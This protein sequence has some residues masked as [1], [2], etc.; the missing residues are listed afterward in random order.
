MPGLHVPNKQ[1]RGF[2]NVI[3]YVIWHEDIGWVFPAPVILWAHLAAD[4]TFLCS[5]SFIFFAPCL[6]V[7]RAYT[8][9]LG[10]TWNLL[11]V[12]IIFL[13]IGLRGSCISCICAWREHRGNNDNNSSI[14]AVLGCW[15]SVSY[16]Q[17]LYLTS[18]KMTIT[19]INTLVFTMFVET[20]WFGQIGSG[21]ILC[22]FH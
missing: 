15:L 10:T 14:T 16:L 13:G 6:Y 19:F 1:V 7:E 18:C 5:Y 17:L 21:S 20:N 8:Q 22:R 12:W 9:V 3:S 2:K 11:G 4:P